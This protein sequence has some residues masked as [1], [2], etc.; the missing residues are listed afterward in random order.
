[1]TWIHGGSHPKLWERLRVQGTGACTSGVDWQYTCI[2]LSDVL[3]QAITEWGTQTAN[4]LGDSTVR[5]MSLY[6]KMLLLMKENSQIIIYT[7][8]VVSPSIPQKLGE[9]EV[10]DDFSFQRALGW[11][12]I[13]SPIWSRFPFQG[14][15]HQCLYHRESGQM[16]PLGH[17]R[18]QDGDSQRELALVSACSRNSNRVVF[19]LLQVL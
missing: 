8:L 5:V 17:W 6:L 16:S 18:S 13:N 3:P 4:F 15:T 1:M 12:G 19:Q 2:T 9:L 10:S 11:R 14:H 7:F